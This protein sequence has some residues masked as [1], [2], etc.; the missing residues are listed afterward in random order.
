MR[1]S[2]D[3]H[4][5]L[6]DL[7]P[8]GLRFDDALARIASAGDMIESV[9]EYNSQLAGHGGTLYRQVCRITRPDPHL[10]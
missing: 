4:V 8:S 9:G 3:E 2:A 7:T 6:Q 1:L 5:V 10:A